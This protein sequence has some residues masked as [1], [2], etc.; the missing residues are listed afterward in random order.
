MRLNVALLS[1]LSGSRAANVGA[2]YASACLHLRSKQVIRIA[3]LVKAES[4][5]PKNPKNPKNPKI[6]AAPPITSASLRVGHRAADSLSENGGGAEIL[7][8][9]L[10]AGFGNAVCSSVGRICTRLSVPDALGSSRIE[11]PDALG[12]V[13]HKPQCQTQDAVD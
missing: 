3:L 1:S 5:S 7:P 4:E 12:Q 10:F 11:C 9:L 8:L 2:R 6:D 13:E